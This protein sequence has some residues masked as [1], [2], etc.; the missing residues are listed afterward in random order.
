M[1]KNLR[2]RKKKWRLE[3][4]IT[5][6][7]FN[8]AKFISAPIITLLLS[9]SWPSILFQHVIFACK[10]ALDY[11]IP[12]VPEHVQNAIKRENYLAQEALQKL[13][14]QHTRQAQNGGAV[15]AR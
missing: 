12:D 1:Q 11:I 4:T 13:Q 2:V 15:E 14:I 5:D 10:F 3:F 9:F 7:I 8:L 6:S